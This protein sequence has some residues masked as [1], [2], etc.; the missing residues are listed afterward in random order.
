[1]RGSGAVPGQ[2]G[3]IMKNNVALQVRFE[4]IGKLPEVAVVAEPSID[5]V[6]GTTMLRAQWNQ[7]KGE[8]TGVP[9]KLDETG[10]GTKYKAFNKADW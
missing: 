9:Y 3:K 7:C 2:Q 4:N 5:G 10:Q 6:Y 8:L 1:M